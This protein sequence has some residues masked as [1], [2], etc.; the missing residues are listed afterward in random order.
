[1]NKKVF[2]VKLAHSLI[3][4]FQV[5]CIAYMLYA[6]ITR[7]FS[8]FL[9]IPI[10]SIVINGILL[11]FNEGRCPFTNLAEKYGAES[12]SV[13]DLFLPKIIADNI[14]RTF[15]PLFIITLIIV[16]IRFF[17]GF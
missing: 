8:L 15:T 10:V 13:T 5:A 12:G 16:A 7:N 14:F 11:Y 1:L 4:W 2:L 3:F 17:F 9:L 6:A